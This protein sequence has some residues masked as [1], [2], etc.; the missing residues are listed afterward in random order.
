[1]AGQIFH[2]AAPDDHN[3]VL[4]E[5]VADARNI[6]RHLH[7]VGQPDSGHFAQ[8]RIGFFGRYGFNLNANSFFKR[9][10]IKSG[11]VFQ[12]VKAAL[13]SHRF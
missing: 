4:L 6:G 5:I 7:A 8:S 1:M 12:P 13:Q 10:G 9:R 11:F 2:P 3:R